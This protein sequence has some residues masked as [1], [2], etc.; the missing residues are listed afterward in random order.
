ML[1]SRFF[2]LATI[3]LLSGCTTDSLEALRPQSQAEL[4]DE[5]SFET[6][7]L[8]LMQT[9]CSVNGCHDGSNTFTVPLTNYAQ[10]RPQIETIGQVL[11]DGSM[12][13]G[14]NMRADELEL[15]LTW[16]DQGG[17]QN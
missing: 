8:P 7:V 12:P 9:Y 3:L 17:P 1:L 14:R 5:V 2:C 16:I 13:I 11:R 15:I 10:I 6:H 4:P